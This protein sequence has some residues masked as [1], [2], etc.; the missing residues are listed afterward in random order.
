M[1]AATA[2]IDQATDAPIRS[3]SHPRTSSAVVELIGALAG[4]RVLDVGAGAGYFASLLGARAAAAGLVPSQVITACD[5][6]P[7]QFQYRDVACDRID[8]NGRLPFADA[9]FDVAC[10]IEVVEH[11]EDQFAFARELARIVKP[12]GRAIVT[13]PNVLNMNGRLRQVACGFAPMFNPLP[14]GGATAD[15]TAGGYHG[16]SGHIHPVA[17]YYLAYQLRRA[18]FGRVV[19]HGDRTKG[20]AA[21]LAVL[22]WPLIAYGRWSLAR[23]L[24]RK[25]PAFAADNRELLPMI[26]SWRMLTARTAIVEAWR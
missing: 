7:E 4:A 13:T 1:S 25:Q 26:N 18:G 2:D 17:P 9:T 14:A 24:A 23:R 5:L 8:A 21:A 19:L 3:F 20:S 6:H 22:L 15:T 16:A 12:G 11:L 10:S